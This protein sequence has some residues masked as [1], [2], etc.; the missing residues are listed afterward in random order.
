[1]SV[2]VCVCVCVC[3]YPLG[4]KQYKADYNLFLTHLPLLSPLV[5]SLSF[6]LPNSQS[7]LPCFI[8]IIIIIIFYVLD[9]GSLCRQARVQWRDLSPLQ[10]PPPGFKRFSCLSLPSSWDYR[11]VPPCPANFCVFS[12][13]RVSPCWPGWSRSP[14]LVIRLPWPP[15]VLELEV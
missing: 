10:S 6:S 12:R 15:K 8:I 3:V 5:L 1:M 7:V 13:D 9:R 11:C 4:L 2:C 14:D